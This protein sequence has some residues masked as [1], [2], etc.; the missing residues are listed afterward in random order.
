MPARLEVEIDGINTG[1]KRTLKDSLTQ[2]SAFNKSLNF[3]PTGVNAINKSLTDTKKLLQD[4]GNL[5]A[6]ARNSLGGTIN[7]TALQQER[8]ALAA[9]RT[10]AQNYRTES[11][12]LAAQLAALRLQTTQNRQA[13]TAASG[14]YKEAQ[15][16]LTALGAAI[17]GVQGGFRSTDPA[18][19]AQIR[20]YRQLNDELKRFDAQLGNHQ[21]DVGRYG[22]ALEGLKGLALTYFGFSA[23]LAAG[24]QVL[25]NNAKISDSL[26]DVRRT[27]GLT[28]KEANS[29][30][31][32]LK[33]INTRTSLGDLLG[34]S[35]IG[36]QLGITKTQLA[37]FTK[38]VDELAVTLSGELQGGAEG[39]AKSLGVL[40]NVFKVTASNSGD[41]EKSYN[42][43]GSAIL[44]LGQS[45]LATG[46]FLADFGERVGGVA[47]Q[48]GIA[49]PVILSYGAVLQENG[50]SAEV[51]GTA[52]KRL[53]SAIS[54]NSGKFFQVAKFAD[55]NLT[56]KQ[57]NTIVNTDTKRALDLFFAGINKGGASTIAFNTI[58]KSLKISGAGASQVVSALANNTVAL[59]GHIQQATKDFNEATLSGEQFA[60]KNDNLAGSID[61]LGKSFE[62]VTTS[63][64]IQT[65]FKSIVDG[66]TASV[67][68]V[69]VLSQA[70]SIFYNLATR[71]KEFIGETALTSREKAI[72]ATIENAKKSGAIQIKNQVSQ[73]EAF[74]LQKREASLL[75]EINS[76]YLEQ[77]RIFN[78]LDPGDRTLTQVKAFQKLEETVRFQKAFVKGLKD[79][80]DKLYRTVK[81]S[82]AAVPDA[83]K[84]K[85]KS[86]KAAK[87]TPVNRAPEILR[88]AGA[89]VDLVGLSGVDKQ[90]ETVRLKYIKFYADLLDNAKKSAEGRKTLEADLFTL[91]KN[92]AAE[93]GKIIVGE[94]QRVSDEIER[95]NNIAAENVAETKARELAE[96]NK[97]YDAEILKAADATNIIIALNAAKLREQEA[98]NQ[99]YEAK[100]IEAQTE[101]TNK[102]QDV[103]ERQFTLNESF[104]NKTTQ[105]NKQALKDRLKDIEDHFK[106]LKKLYA[107]NP[108]ALTVL[109]IS[110]GGAK[111]Q[112]TNNFNEAENAANERILSDLAVGFGSKFYQ[113]LTTINQQADQSFTSIAGSIGDSVTGMLQDTFQNKLGSIL[114]KFVEDGEISFKDAAIGIAGLAGGLVSGLTKKT[115]STGQAIGGALTGAA[116]G[117]AVAGPIG[118]AV[119]GLVGAVGG[120]FGAS[121]ARKEE[122]ALQKQQLEEAKK[123]TELMRENAKSY[124]SSIIGRMTDQGI[125]TG[126]DINAFGEVEFQVSGKNLKAVL[127]RV[128]NSRG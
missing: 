86:G 50:V 117:F 70:L 79:E 51:A 81:R 89:D 116:A 20:E 11:A 36:G 119:G 37:G 68:A 49:L 9:S 91:Q 120:L 57:F 53:I 110:E 108:L 72:N 125:V 14:S 25:L 42:Q 65:F 121:K 75:S 38:A 12:R 62:D 84:P 102:I 19:Q 103:A 99:K 3:K 66:A 63:G 30:A 100:R 124:T 115:D 58:L 34:I 67:K 64:A 107:N 69:G 16:R 118:A 113:T 26:S 39:I 52:F 33:G 43:I 90:V 123:Q 97:R 13:T 78:E 48:A 80:Y 18:I 94:Q 4:V 23:L 76:K 32:S 29:L 21:R 35:V 122:Q 46:D 106:D 41:V 2:L 6:A 77:K 31:E 87:A 47:K 96:V 8:L 111:N 10:E 24:R 1:L 98:I 126:A 7:T 61:K 83:F 54:S 92:E 104:S 88:Q 101:L 128:N 105:K 82:D 15:Q 71:P 93:N 95:I 60:I 85:D 74:D 56:L 44:G 5:S 114:K 17:R 27:A 59:N 45:G 127:S 40:D 55:A 109:G 22:K 73:K 28:A 112:A